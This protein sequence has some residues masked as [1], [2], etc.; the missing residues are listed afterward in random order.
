MRLRSL[1]TLTMIC[2]ASVLYFAGCGDDDEPKPA[3]P[4]ADA[5]PDGTT[6][7]GG[8]TGDG[9]IGDVIS[10]DGPPIDGAT[11]KL[12][13]TS[14][15]VNTDC[16]QNNCDPKTKICQGGG[17][18]QAAGQAC[19]SGLDCCTNSCVG[20]QCSGTQCVSDNQACTTSDQCC[21]GSCTGPDGGA[22]TCK[23][24]NGSCKTAGNACG[25][26]NECCSKV[27]SNGL[28]Q[29]DISICTQTGDSCDSNFDCCGGLC[30]KAV[31]AA[32]GVCEV[33]DAPGVP[34]CLVNGQ[35]CGDAP[36][37]DDGG[38]ANDAGI[39]TCGGACCSRSCAPFGLTG[40]TVCQPPSGCRPTGETCRTGKDCC[41]FGGVKNVTGTGEC[42]IVD[43]AGVGRCDN[44]NGC[45]P[46]GAICKL[47]VTSCNDENNCC[48]G[49]VNQNPLVC[50]QDLLGIPRCTLA[51]INCDDAGTQAGKKCA[52]SADC[53]G[54]PCVP[55][56]ADGGVPPFVCGTSCV[57]SGGTC[58]TSGDC[59]AGIPCTL[60]PGSASGIC[61]GVITQPDGGPPVIGPP[62]PDAGPVDSGTPPPPVCALA[63]Q[64][65][66]VDG[67]CCNPTVYKCR[68]GTCKIPI[69]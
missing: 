9:D 57:P 46:A 49:N 52:T 44:G 65:C 68:N 7:D 58:T 28:C 37:A 39:P 51:G 5:T 10:T 42:S 36:S 29:G 35:V 25:G 18:C 53:C 64:Q 13:G 47:A 63:G 15:A 41:G 43:D 32:Y 8:P 21:G 38:V 69:Q 60:L 59:C 4:G 55:N 16:C 50:Q 24:L 3:E 48:S 31:G 20:G 66:S 11:C 61:G 33:V 1:V 19:S 2:G 17:E 56:L 54:L 27:C 26:N 30:N 12:N 14:C 6:G 45:R 40:V 22:K 67:D 62:P 23:P 34:G